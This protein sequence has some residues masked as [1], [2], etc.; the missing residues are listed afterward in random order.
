MTPPPFSPV[1]S[2]LPDLV[3]DHDHEN[4]Q[5]ISDFNDL[6]DF[7]GFASDVCLSLFL[8][9]GAD[10]SPTRPPQSPIGLLHHLGLPLVLSDPPLLTL[11]VMLSPL[12]LDLLTR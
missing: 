12:A 6:F 1:P 8:C 2:S 11:E 7:D 3:G 5:T 9:G 4:D 10:S